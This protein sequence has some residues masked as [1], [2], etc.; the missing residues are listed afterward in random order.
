LTLAVFAIFCSVA[1]SI[2]E[3][4]REGGELQYP[5]PDVKN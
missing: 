1:D 3:R 5:L 2:G 4:R